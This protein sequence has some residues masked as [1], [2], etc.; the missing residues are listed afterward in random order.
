M[1][2]S[3]QTVSIEDICK[4][5]HTQDNT[6]YDI[7]KKV[8]ISMLN[9]INSTTNLKSLEKELL[10]LTR[11]KTGMLRKTDIIHVYRQLIASGEMKKNVLLW[12]ILQKCKARNISGLSVV[13]LLLAPFPDGQQF[14]CKHNCYYCPDESVKNGAEA[15][16]P[17]SYLMRE[18][19]VQRG[20]RNG[21]DA[22]KQMIDRL[23]SLFKCGHEVSKLEIILEGGTYTEYPVEYLER[24]HRDIF[25]SANTYFQKDKRDPLDLKSEIII[26]QSAKVPIIGICIETRPDA[27]DEFWIK[28]FRD[29]GVTR[30]Q[31]GLQHTNNTILKKVNRGHTVECAIDAI[32]L[33]KDNCFKIDIHLMPDLPNS[34]PEM[35]K[36]MFEDVFWSDKFQPDQVK[37]YPCEVTPYTVIEKWYKSGKYIPY[38]ETNPDDLVN[39]VKYGMEIC[40]PWVRL[41]RVVRDIPLDYIQSGNMMPN[42]RQIIDDKFKAEGKFCK[43]MRTR[44]T[45]RHSQY[46]LKDAVYI[47][48]KYYASGSWEYFISLESKDQ[49][50]LF[51]F[52][53]LRIPPKMHKPL[54]ECLTDIGLIRELHV[55]GNLV[56]V[57][58]KSLDDVQH[59]GVGKK[60]VKKA[61]W[62]AWLNGCIGTAII[63][64]EGVKKYYEKQGYY[65]CETYMIKK[66]LLTSAIANY[67]KF[68]IL[69]TIFGC[70]A[71]VIR[72]FRL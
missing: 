18:P 58:E 67:R 38:C 13:T 27:I 70:W 23:D 42:L 39:V 5:K 69:S 8:I 9:I 10:K 12:S 72:I 35:D 3:K 46:K 6:K 59:K 34:T 26:N 44:E 31:L 7:C 29:W 30:V 62:I 51:G 14:S 32:Q 45:G 19:A 52:I 1:S 65:E 68:I 43:D 60:L 33:L 55:Y 16:M 2:C 71:C 21:W 48:R 61:E 11:R 25:W 64:G 28:K 15:D 57:G 22:V 20:F 53:R 24:F 50:A 56:P 63:S 36:K 4:D 17:R 40:P 49:V 37:I 41:P 66:Y 54:F 47:V